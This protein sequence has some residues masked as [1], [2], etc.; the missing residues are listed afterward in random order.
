MK[1]GIYRSSRPS[2][3]QGRR[4]DRDMLLIADE[5]LFDQLLA[6]ERKRTERTG[7]PFVL[8]ILDIAELNGS[9]PAR[10]IAEICNAIEAETR[11]ID[12]YG[13][14]RDSLA[15]GVIFTALRLAERPAILSALAGKTERA[16][17]AALEPADVKKVG[18]SFHFFPE[19]FIPK[20]PPFDSDH[21]LYPDLIRRDKSQVLYHVLKRS[22]DI[23]GSLSGLIL[24]SPLFLLIAVLIKCTSR[25][26]ILF[27]QCRVGKF[28]R[29][30]NFLKFRT[31]Y[32]NNDP[33]IHEQY[34]RR[35][36]E[37][38]HQA[39]TAPGAAKPVF[40]I[41]NDP[42]IAPIGSFLRKSSLDEL[43][44]FINVLRGEM[45]LVGPRPPIPYEVA[46]YRFWHRRRII[47]VKPGITGMWQIYGRS[48]TTFDEMVRLDLRYVREQ[49]LWLDLKIILKTPRAVLSGKGAF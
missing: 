7:D 17:S 35:L 42:R 5:A 46:A 34:I 2:P 43:P 25:G 49:S 10:K 37:Q 1:V 39:A 8:M 40:K 14:Y 20:N 16:L 6:L 22:I 23:A 48:R 44:Q 24:F 36:I 21:K 11:D 28:G 47:E 45:S 31:M 4:N 30:F 18:I 19:D 26:P 38:K 27:Q 29:E 15:I 32:I 41:V 33:A 13:W 12:L 9:A 3:N